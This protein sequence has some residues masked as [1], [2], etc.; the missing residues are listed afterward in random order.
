MQLLIAVWQAALT[1]KPKAA[2]APSES[3]QPLDAGILTAS[4]PK[5]EV[6]SESVCP[7]PRRPKPE[8][9]FPGVN[10]GRA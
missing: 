9:P 4:Q 6:T 5:V 3:E 2:A 7:I 1:L 10:R 8:N